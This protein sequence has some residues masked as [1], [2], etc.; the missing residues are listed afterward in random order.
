[1]RISIDKD[2]AKP[3]YRQIEERLRSG[4]LDGSLATETRLPATRQLA[5][6]LGVSRATVDSAYAELATSGLVDRRAGSGTY[7]A[8]AGRAA[9]DPGEWPLWQVEAAQR[10]LGVASPGIQAIPANLE[11]SGVVSFASVSDP[12][13]FRLG[14]YVRALTEAAKEA[15]AAALELPPPL[16]LEAL[17]AEF[18]NL[19]SS[20]G[21]SAPPSSILVSSGARQSLSLVASTLL[22]AGD[23]V[24][25]E[26]PTDELALEFF[27]VRELR[28]VGCPVDSR[29]MRVELLES[30]LQRHHPKLI[31][32][33]PTFHD[34]T[35]SVMS[36]DRRRQLVR[37][38]AKYNIPI[39]E[40]DQA[41]DLRFKGR[42]AP[43]LATLG[44]SGGVIYARSF[45]HAVAP[46]LPLG[47]LV[48]RG[49]ILGALARAKRAADLGTNGLAQRAF[50]RYLAT[51]D[52]ARH[53]RRLRRANLERLRILVEALEA[54]LPL[55]EFSPPKGGL[56][57]WVRL[58]EGV[59]VAALL[60]A[61]Q[62]EGVEF[63]AGPRFFVE[64]ASGG[65]YARLSFA[66]LT[67][68]E[69]LEGVERLA[70]AVAHVEDETAG[71]EVA[72]LS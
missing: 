16:G 7:V 60:P 15:G 33:A 2:Y 17:R 5:R 41:S 32:T 21:V 65:Q 40:S 71:R 47:F 62:R 44:E 36:S 8:D 3:L 28:I 13:S 55:L 31:Y 69:I 57:L 50:A 63:G 43:A 29:G 22:T 1:M 39:L 51:G 20:Q 48:A 26:D 9:P 11:A 59:D 67:E 45:S 49:P 70:R 14:E 18:T 38:G 52:Y 25:V 34:P 66:A 6:E 10:A 12:R 27:R 64:P 30:L 56:Y 54:H 61:S 58:P 23:T 72:A 24:V 46:G 35:G 4:I 68:E 42:G 53:V 37:L 19:L